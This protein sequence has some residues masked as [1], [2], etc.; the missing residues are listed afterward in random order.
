MS[1]IANKFNN[2]ETFKLSYVFLN[3]I[4]LQSICSLKK[5]TNLSLFRFNLTAEGKKKILRKFLWEI[6]NNYY[7]IFSLNVNLFS[8]NFLI[9]QKN[10]Q[11]NLFNSQNFLR[12]FLIFSIRN[13][14]DIKFLAKSKNIEFVIHWWK[15]YR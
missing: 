12:I 6:Q 5:L 13:R 4:G 1:I 15:H 9:I 7:N 10:F 2:L 8:Y 14:I 11:K 3:E